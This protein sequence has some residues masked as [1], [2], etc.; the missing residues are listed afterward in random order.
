MALFTE[1]VAGL[2]EDIAD[3]EV[4]A[5]IR[6]SCRAVFRA[7][8]RRSAESLALRSILSMLGR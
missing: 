1:R 5:E 8:A 7:S 6:K 3:P 4:R 2:I